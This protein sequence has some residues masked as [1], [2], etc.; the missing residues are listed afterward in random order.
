MNSLD[1]R[2]IHIGMRRLLEKWEMSKLAKRTKLDSC[3]LTKQEVDIIVIF[4][5]GNK[6]SNCRNM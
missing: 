1:R 6:Y 4:K 5:F 2:G 3:E